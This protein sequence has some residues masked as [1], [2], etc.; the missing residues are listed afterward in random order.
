MPEP[1]TGPVAYCPVVVPP[2]GTGTLNGELVGFCTALGVFSGLNDGLAVGVAGFAA[3]DFGTA[4][5][6]V[7]DGVTFFCVVVCAV[8]FCEGF[9]AP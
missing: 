7:G 9:E 1:L 3:C 5:V 6:V 4:V 2:E 8:V